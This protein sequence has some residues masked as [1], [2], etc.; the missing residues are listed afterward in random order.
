MR[1]FYYQLDGHTHL[2][3]VRGAMPGANSPIWRGCNTC[4]WVVPGT[5][6]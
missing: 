5:E 1:V 6:E 2:V 3:C 4:C